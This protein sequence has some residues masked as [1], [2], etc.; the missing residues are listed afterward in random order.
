MLMSNCQFKFLLHVDK[1]LKFFE[2]S[3]QLIALAETIYIGNMEK[4]CIYDFLLANLFSSYSV[5]L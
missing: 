1:H 3:F 2:T 5:S 4:L